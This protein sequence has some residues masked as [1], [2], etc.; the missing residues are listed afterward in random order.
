MDFFDFRKLV[1]P[2]MIENKEEYLKEYPY[3]F[4]GT[5]FLTR[6]GLELYIVTARHITDTSGVDKDSIRITVAPNS[7]AFITIFDE[8]FGNSPDNTVGD[9]HDI[10]VMST[11]TANLP[12]SRAR[13][14]GAFPL[15]PNEFIGDSIAKNTD[16]VVIGYPLDNQ[17]VDYENKHV[18][19]KASVIEGH[20]M[21][22]EH[23]G[24]H[25]MKISTPL[26]TTS[27]NGLSGSPVF[28]RDGNVYHL[29]GM[30][31]TGSSASNTIRF[32]GIGGAV[33]LI[34]YAR[35]M[36]RDI[37]LRK[38]REKGLSIDEANLMKDFLVAFFWRIPH[39][40]LV[41]EKVF[42]MSLMYQV[43][44]LRVF[45][46]DSILCFECWTIN[47]NPRKVFETLDAEQAVQFLETGKAPY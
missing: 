45:L 47:S 40:I 35:E 27:I 15:E 42:S 20:Y 10:I 36:Y 13:Q 38:V 6:I 9:F 8:F 5:C 32:I 17:Y 2:I 33:Q 43:R 7:N 30:V 16:L 3:A 46:N 26:D 4:Y 37:F 14:I 24:R 39:P 22:Y 29:L 21:E 41:F 23:P 1:R 19:E 31:I 25:V 12:L 44:E 34:R 11:Y 18:H 28:H